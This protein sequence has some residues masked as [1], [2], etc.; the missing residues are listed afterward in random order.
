MG[1]W[2][3]D[4]AVSVVVV[5]VVCIHL[6]PF[7]LLALEERRPHPPKP[8]EIEIFAPGLGALPKFLKGPFARGCGD[9]ASPQTHAGW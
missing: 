9:V 1:D 3:P 7:S 5:L 4:P 8:K 6:L 2:G